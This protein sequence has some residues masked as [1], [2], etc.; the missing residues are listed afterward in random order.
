MRRSVSDTS[1]SSH[2]YSEKDNLGYNPWPYNT[3]THSGKMRYNPETPIRSRRNR[4]GSSISPKFITPRSISPRHC[5]VSRSFSTPSVGNHMDYP[6]PSPLSTPIETPLSTPITPTLRMPF[7]P[8]LSEGLHNEMYGYTPREPLSAVQAVPP[9]D[10][11]VHST[12][13]RRSFSDQNISND[14]SCDEVK[15]INPFYKPPSFLRSLKPVSNPEPV[16]TQPSSLITPPNSAGM[17]TCPK[18]DMHA[19]LNTIDDVVGMDAKPHCM[20]LS[21]VSAAA[22]IAAAPSYPYEEYMYPPQNFYPNHY[23]PEM[24][25]PHPYIPDKLP[26]FEDEASGLVMDDPKQKPAQPEIEKPFSCETCNKSF[27]RIEHLKRHKKTHTNERPFA[28][29][30]PDCGRKFSRNDNLKAHVLTHAKKSGKDEHVRRLVEAHI[31]QA[32]RR[33]K[34]RAQVLA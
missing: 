31:N 11:D 12:H 13:S 34:S 25:M 22:A 7:E 17:A 32:P 6:F 4:S 20:G 21:P 14:S 30:I 2:A 15:G 5:T 29:P 23:M 28:C 1:P 8:T 9:L 26:E 3:P 18:R 33:R 16:Q 19:P 27:R 10:A 24:H